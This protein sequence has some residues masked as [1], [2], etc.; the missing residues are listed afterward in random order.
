M[1]TALSEIEEAGRVLAD[2]AAY[3]DELRLHAA[4][5]NLARC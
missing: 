4:M 3:A 1:A 2:P 5:T